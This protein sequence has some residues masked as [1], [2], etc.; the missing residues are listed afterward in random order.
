MANNK[1]KTLDDLFEDTLKDIFYAENKILKALPKMA[2]AAHSDELKAAFE[3]HLRETEGHVSRLE[4]VFK[5]I[6][7]APKGKKCEAIEALFAG[8]IDMTYVGP[9]PAINGYVRSNGEAVRVVA[10]AASGGAGRTYD[11]RGFTDPLAISVWN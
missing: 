4:K 3:K 2:K 9:N 11:D 6:E 8:A 1:N 7:V 5:L 10:G